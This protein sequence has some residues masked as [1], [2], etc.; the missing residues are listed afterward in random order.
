MINKPTFICIGAQKAGTTWLSKM[1][2]KHPE[3]WITPV[4]ELHYF[5]YVH[6]QEMDIPKRMLNELKNTLERKCNGQAVSMSYLQYLSK[7][8]L[9]DKYDDEYYI[10]LFES[11][12]KDVIG[13]L[14]PEY[15]MLTEEG[16]FHMRNLLGDIKIIFIMRNPVQRAWSF[17]RMFLR[18]DLANGV[19][20][21]PERWIKIVNRPGN[22]KR[23]DYKHTVNTYEKIFR[24]DKILYLFYDDICLEPLRVLRDVCL[25][26]GVSYDEN[27]FLSFVEQRYNVN[28]EV[29]IPDKVFEFLKKEFE[30]QD[31]F[32]RSRFNP[33]QFEL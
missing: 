33:V 15:S 17:A 26:L 16:V 27:I 13:E 28:P 25:F 1:L 2:E 7:V 12:N 14:T 21:S 4:K 19:S 10:S 31:E 6:L 9:T 8:A 22:K 23:T 3:I 30:E 29:K 5:D 20:I 18:Q 32:V 11:A 24:P